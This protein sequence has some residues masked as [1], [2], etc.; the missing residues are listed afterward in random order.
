MSD[1]STLR[2][3]V[4][5]GW[6]HLRQRVRWSLLALRLRALLLARRAGQAMRRGAGA[7][8]RW[9]TAGQAPLPEQPPVEEQRTVWSTAVWTDARIALCDSASDDP[10][11]VQVHVFPGVGLL[12]EVD[13]DGATPSRILGDPLV[14]AIRRDALPP[15]VL[16]Q[17]ARIAALEERVRYVREWGPAVVTAQGR[18]MVEHLEELAGCSVALTLV[19]EDSTR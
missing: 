4:A 12:V 7:V 1:A 18:A 16:D 14:R 8:G 5:T 17:L 9:F 2:D 3:H 10:D 6:E 11:R 15:E 13:A 19:T